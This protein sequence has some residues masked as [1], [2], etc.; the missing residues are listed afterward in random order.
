VL[1]AS[2]PR[3]VLVTG[4]SGLVGRKLVERLAAHPGTIETLVGVDLA[5][6]APEAQRAGV[7]YES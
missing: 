5:P 3:S 6:P 7:V 1:P 4:A 2:P